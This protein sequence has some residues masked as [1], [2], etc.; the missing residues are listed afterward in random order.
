MSEEPKK[1]TA[2]EAKNDEKVANIQEKLV[3]YSKWKNLQTDS[4]E[5]EEEV[6]EEEKDEAYEKFLGN[7]KRWTSEDRQKYIDG[8]DDVALL[9]S[10]EE[11]DAQ[12]GDMT[13]EAM[14][15]LMEE[16]EDERSLALYFKGKGNESYAKG[17]KVRKQEKRKGYYRHALESYNKAY[18]Y[19]LEAVRPP[20]KV[21]KKL[22]KLHSTILSN[23]ALVH[24]EL[25]N[26]G[27]CR[28]D[29]V[30]AVIAYRK[31]VK[32][33]FRFAKASWEV[34]KY[35]EGLE[36]AIQ[37]LTVEPENKSLL[38][39]HA[40]LVKKKKELD[41]KELKRKKELQQLDF[42][43]AKVMKAAEKR[44]LR[45]GPAVFIEQYKGTLPRFMSSVQMSCNC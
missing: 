28:R 2:E 3:D 38:E 21:S 19:V 14:K 37:G 39:I 9:K 5:E 34:R 25:K 30:K 23:R 16:G 4:D 1:V 20:N 17:R 18:S 24:S 42:K 32:A 15:A 31:N 7:A 12:G 6:D 11:L 27:S 26:Y 29:C 40:K 22:A 43:V 13:T 35:L 41:A 36:F 44:S 33:Y 8:L 10:Q 45:I